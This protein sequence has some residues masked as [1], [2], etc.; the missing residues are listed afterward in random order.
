MSARSRYGTMGLLVRHARRG[1]VAT[2]LMA[3]LVAV[4]VFAVAAAPRAVARLGTEEVRRTVAAMPPIVHDLRGVGRVGLPIGLA[5][6]PAPR[7][8]APTDG[9]IGLFL[10]DLPEPVAS[11]A[12][13]P[14]W[15]ASTPSGDALRTDGEPASRF[16]LRL[17]TDPRWLEQV[18]IVS[19]D[20]PAAWEGD[21][22]EPAEQPPI[23][24]A[25]STAVASEAGVEVGDSL[26]F[27]GLQL[28]VTGLYEPNDETDAYWTHF[29]DL[30]AP[31]VE[32]EPG[33]T[34]IVRASVYVDPGSLGGLTTSIPDGS[35]VAW[36]PLD[37]SPLTAANA[38][39]VAAQLRAAVAADI[40]LPYGGRLTFGTALA[41]ELEEAIGR[42][43]TVAGLLALGASGL[44]GVLLAVF[45]L[46][47]GSI[48]DRRRPVL[49]L[50]RA[51]GASEPEV[52]AAM[53]LEGLAIAMPAMAL[54][55][56]AAVAV[57]PEPVGADAWV[58]PIIVG[59]AVPVL[60]PLLSGPRP[61]RA[62]RE[63]GRAAAGDRRIRMIAEIAVVGLAVVSIALLARRGIDPPGD[64]G[65][66]DPLILLAPLLIAAAL[67]IGALRLYPIPLRLV[68]AGRRGR[69]GAIALL[70]SARAVR[71][72]VFGFAASFALLLGVSVVVFSAVLGSTLREAIVAG[73]R[74]RVG[75]DVQISAANL[76]PEVIAAI[77]R[78]DGVDDVVA[79]A[80]VTGVR[81]LGHAGTATVTLV[82]ADTAAL[83]R[84][85]PDIP[86]ADAPRDG[87]VPLVV[88]SGAL[89]RAGSDPRIGNADVE[90]VA[91]LP[92]EALPGGARAWAI[93]DTR[94]AADVGRA[95]I[96]TER[97]LVG[98][99]DDADA[100]TVAARIEEAVSAAQS[101]DRLGTVSVLSAQLLLDEARSS[102]LTRGVEASLP[103]VSA[104]A[105]LL[106]LIGVALA[107]V[108]TS[109]TRGRTVAVLRILGADARQQRGV[110]LWELAP[111]VVASVL[112]G[113]AVGFALP[114]VLS[115]VI[116]LRPFVGGTAPPAPTV[117]PASIS[118][119]LGAV[120]L[121][122][123]AA[124]AVA[125]FVGRRISVATTLKMGER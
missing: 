82:A 33:S 86:A 83:H 92:P 34:P 51:R 93:I 67:C 87:T 74:D 121:F 19:G 114:A 90:A 71:S 37:D 106:T 24:I 116:D 1:I 123:F 55:I 78:M 5:G 27:G 47:I 115:Q 88:S 42:T 28:R 25:V 108:A 69:D 59:A 61:F 39:T 10:D 65:G 44:L 124:G 58:L 11:M 13:E 35:L 3:A 79:L 77:G 63:D 68:L 99:R 95:D 94:L 80:P 4:S 75:A 17:A 49:A 64:A 57:I 118:L 26:R 43:G 30:A 102:P 113:T 22:N 38:S 119:A 53:A 8:V 16:I 18:R 56:A 23:D 72:P 48:V 96:E 21:E 120:L 117:D 29:S 9:A 60:F 97:L 101:D 66:V 50:A 7:L 103:W 52:R 46:G 32:R 104:A 41:D 111:P 31:L 40:A 125:F 89:A 54:G 105:L 85:R 81:V 107:T 36:I 110:L 91:E 112:V 14:H 12:G 45:A 20:P 100:A 122:A 109:G 70:G 98:L 6:T 62:E 15:V 2:L 76:G 73:T 84:V